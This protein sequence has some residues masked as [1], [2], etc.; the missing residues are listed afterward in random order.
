[1]TNYQINTLAKILNQ[2]GVTETCGVLAG[3][4]SGFGYIIE[5][6]SAENRVHIWFALNTNMTEE[7]YKTCSIWS[8][9]LPSGKITE[10]LAF[11][12]I[13]ATNPNLAIR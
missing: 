4:H 12:N 2:N 5:N 13:P 3:E 7:K 6:L 1:M 9:F 8:A 11:L 10:L